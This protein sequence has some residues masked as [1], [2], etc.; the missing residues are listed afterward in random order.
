[1]DHGGQQ[2]T[3]AGETCYSRVRV[4]GQVYQSSKTIPNVPRGLV[5]EEEKPP[6]T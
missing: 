6:L 4:A 5:L 3:M 2:Q 1:M